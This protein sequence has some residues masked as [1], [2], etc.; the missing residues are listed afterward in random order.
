MHKGMS[1]RSRSYRQVG[2]LARREK[3]ERLFEKTIADDI[4]IVKGGWKMKE[5]NI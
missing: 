2:S 5:K 4:N 1:N 3:K